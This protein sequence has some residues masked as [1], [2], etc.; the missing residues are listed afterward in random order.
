MASQCST[1]SQARAK[2][3]DRLKDALP[4]HSLKIEWIKCVGNTFFCKMAFGVK[5]IERCGRGEEESDETPNSMVYFPID[6][7]GDHTTMLCFHC[8]SRHIPPRRSLVPEPSVTTENRIGLLSTGNRVTNKRAGSLKPKNRIR[9][10]RPAGVTPYHL[11]QFGLDK[12]FP[13]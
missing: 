1:N 9:A 6:P 13:Q 2:A 3:V 7:A 11:V 5:A 10:P 12:R 4:Y 8:E